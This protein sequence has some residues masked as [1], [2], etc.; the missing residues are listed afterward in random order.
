MRNAT[1]YFWDHGCHLQ[2]DEAQLKRRI[3]D[4]LLILSQRRNKLCW[5]LNQAEETRQVKAREAKCRLKWRKEVRARRHSDVTVLTSKHAS[6][7]DDLLPVPVGPTTTISLKLALI[8]F[9]TSK[10]VRMITEIIIISWISDSVP[11]NVQRTITPISTFGRRC[12]YGAL[13]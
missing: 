1:G 13:Y 7:T 9:S 10:T 5:M 8:A 3:L 6:F 4:E 2:D 11:L 12:Y